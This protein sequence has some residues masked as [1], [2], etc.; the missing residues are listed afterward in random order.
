MA[1]TIK[2]IALPRYYALF[3]V[4]ALFPQIFGFNG[5]SIDTVW[6]VV[7]VATL[8]F[9]TGLN[10]ARL[11]RVGFVYIMISTMNQLAALATSDESVTT[12]GINIILMALLIVVFFEY[13]H[14]VRRSSLSD[15][16]QFYK[17]YT[18]FMVIAC[19]YNIII[20]PSSLLNIAGGSLYGTQYICSF[21]DNKN[22][23]GAFLMFGCLAATI[24]RYYLRER[25]WLFVIALFIINELM[26]MC[27]TAIV[28]SLLLLLYSFILA[29]KGFSIKRLFI[30]G[31][32]V[33]ASVIVIG[34]VESINDFVV[35]KLFSSTTSIE[36]RQGYITSMSG[37]IKGNQAIWGYGPTESKI[38]AQTY[39]GN[40]YYHNTYLNVVITNGIVGL[41]LLILSILYAFRISWSVF[42]YDKAAGALC[43]LSCIVYV[44][45]AYVESTILFTT[46]VIS[47]VATIFVI[48]MPILFKTAMRSR[49]LARIND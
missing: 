24:L 6:K 40:Q 42:K 45:Y 37:L 28:L 41:S 48:S 47:M 10:P 34:Q 25:K 1:N 43:A 20:H 33:V 27:R 7:V 16:L 26:A 32:A 11:S 36:S 4:A 18:Y 3:I 9:F 31:L 8:V 14:Q 44:V 5:S 30:V 13:P 21:F 35:G 46:P 38:L 19:I 49:S 29:E 22:T 2:N 15:A 23:F 12:V 39:T 17:I